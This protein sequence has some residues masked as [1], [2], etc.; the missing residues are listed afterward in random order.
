MRQKTSKREQAQKAK[1]VV[2]DRLV[3]SRA[4]NY[5]ATHRFL[6]VGF[7]YLVLRMWNLFFL[8]PNQDV[9]RYFDTSG[10]WLSGLKP[11]AQFQ[12]E[13]PPGGLL[14]FVVPRVLTDNFTRYS[15]LFA[16]EMLIFDLGILYLLARIGNV[17]GN[18]ASNDLGRRYDTTL[19]MLGYLL[20]TGILGY[21]AFERYDLA[22][23][24]LFLVWLYTAMESRRRVIPD[25][26]LAVGIFVKLISVIFL[27]VYLAYL[28]TVDRGPTQEPVKAQLGRIGTWLK[29]E[30][31]IRLATVTGLTL[32]LFVPFYVISGDA[33][34]N[35]LS[36][37][38]DRGIQIESTYASILLFFHHLIREPLGT[39]HVFGAMEVTHPLVRSL[40]DLSAVFT[41]ALLG[42]TSV[43]F[44]LRL[45]R[46]PDAKA[47]NQTLVEATLA[48][49]LVFIFCNKVFS[50]Q[51][52]L[53]LAPL[54]P[55]VV[56]R[57]DT[58]PR[59]WMLGF[60]VMFL[61]TA[62]ILYF[63]YINLIYLEA[64]PTWLLLAR[65]LLVGVMAWS[66]MD[67]PWTWESRPAL[68]RSHERL[69]TALTSPTVR[70]FGFTLCC[71]WVFFAN[72]S[73]TTA[74]DIWIQLRSGEDI[75]KSGFT[76]PYTEIYSSTVAG[77]PFIAHEWLSGVIF[78]ALDWAFGGAGL[79]FLAAFVA[80]GTF[81]LM[82]FTFPRE[83]RHTWWYPA[84]LLFLSYLVAF[85]VLVRPHIFTIVA[86]AALLLAVERWRRN[87]KLRDLLWLIPLQL[88]W[89]NLHGAALFGPAYLGMITGCVG[90][91]VLFPVLQRGGSEPRTLTW[92]DVYQ[93]GGMTAALCLACVV[94]PYGTKIVQ[95]SLD[96]MG[97]EYAKSRVWEWTTPF[98]WSNIS[99]YWLWLYLFGLLLLWVCFLVRIRTV[100]LI[101][102]ALTLLVTYLSI[103]ANRFVPDFAIF[104]FPVIAKTFDS[105][106]RASLAPAL[107]GPRP[108][109][110]IGIATLLFTNCVTYGYA[111]SAREHRPMIGWG[112]GGDMPYQEVDLIKKLGLKGIIF[113]EYSDG[114]LIINKLYPD[115]RV[116]LD[117]RI[118]LYPLDLVDEYDSAYIVPELFRKYVEKRNVN[119][120]LLYRNRA[121]PRVVNYLENSNDWRRLSDT[122]GRL[123]Y[124]RRDTPMHTAF[125]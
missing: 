63:Y 30:G 71:A 122:N 81:F 90:L 111:H 28:Y 20:F 54:A 60:A 92:Q 83:M 74:N 22:C 50:P 58:R 17:I 104:A 52:L 125:R 85:R 95:F 115:V 29:R 18:K 3:E 19:A 51:Y 120:V 64:F 99:Y 49:L 69:R 124:V 15:T 33:L 11:Y 80:L 82:Y 103:R 98:M 53:W 12:L 75:V 43:W 47:R 59:A 48:L 105:V 25:A 93:L 31:S 6:L 10:Q 45:L 97:N 65:N 16:W 32:T 102:F 72:L 7:P 118:D 112:Y 73:E 96:L 113:N 68:A 87:G 117:S 62:L 110:E 108:W 37:H 36:Y 9:K 123:L 78:Y 84:L 38:K 56:L 89:I 24:F 77:R 44:I 1:E 88:V 21:L 5:I 14:L 42:A 57:E 109:V 67:V 26:L 106:A 121:S 119:I 66:L 35:F 4:V 70:Y 8:S 94:N 13:Y 2:V 79:S 41:L 76:M 40:A 107:R 27:P 34:F 114:A 55:L 23:A 101:D 86:Q 46:A 116:V 91:M 61:I 39:N 100:P